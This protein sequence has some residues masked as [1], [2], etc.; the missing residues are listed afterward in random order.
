VLF[1]VAL[2][3]LALDDIRSNAGICGTGFGGSVCD[4]DS[5]SH[6]FTSD[7]GVFCVLIDETFPRGY[8]GKLGYE[9]NDAIIVDYRK[10]LYRY[11]EFLLKM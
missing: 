1:R 7:S 9:N 11:S 2:V 4:P 6:F 8:L 3:K 10:G 5:I